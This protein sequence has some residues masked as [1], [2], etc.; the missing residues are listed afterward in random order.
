MLPS[1]WRIAMDSLTRSWRLFRQ[2]F[3]VLSNEP[4]MLVFPVLSAVSALLLCAS[5]FIPLY[6]TGTL[7][8]V[9][10]HRAGWMDYIPLCSWYYANTFVVVFFNSAMVA[11]AGIRLNG[12]DP[13]VADGFRI[14]CS[15]IHRIAAWTLVAG[16]VGLLLR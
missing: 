14:A 5:F 6:Q 10:R 15:R 4:G 12:G 7:Q 8:A 13:T 1:P 3:T 16:T 2:S 11:C 9:A